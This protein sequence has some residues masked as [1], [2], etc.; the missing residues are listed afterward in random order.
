MVKS[1]VIGD[2]LIAAAR[3]LKEARAGDIT[4][5][6]DARHAAQLH[7]CPASAAV[8]PDTL[9]VNNLTVIRVADPLAALPVLWCICTA[10]P[11]R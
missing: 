11:R 2:L 8:V 5:V 9:P 10:V 7:N 4:F 1:M 3:P 6:E